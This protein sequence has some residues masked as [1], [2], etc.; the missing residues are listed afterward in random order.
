MT[1][2]P[3]HWNVERSVVVA[4]LLV[5]SHL[6]ILCQ[7]P[8]RCLLFVRHGAPLLRYDTHNLRRLFI[9]TITKP[10]LCFRIHR[11]FYPGTHLLTEED[12]GGQRLF[13][14]SGASFA[15]SFSSSSLLVPFSATLVQ[16]FHRR[17]E[18]ESGNTLPPLTSHF[19]RQDKAVSHS[20]LGFARYTTTIDKTRG[21]PN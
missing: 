19:P 8:I 20:Y 4:N 18:H 9:T 11:G 16:S 13:G 12:V 15:F 10:N 3:R 17:K 5:V 1:S 14:A 21:S 7:L 2:F 6:I